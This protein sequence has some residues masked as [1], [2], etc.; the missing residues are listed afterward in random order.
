[1]YDVNSIDT[2]V[3]ERGIKTVIEAAFS[4]TYTIET[5]AGTIIEGSATPGNP[6]AIEQHGDIKNVTIT[7]G[8]DNVKPLRVVK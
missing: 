3:L 7:I 1:M 2:I 4:Y 6:L 8:E 5:L